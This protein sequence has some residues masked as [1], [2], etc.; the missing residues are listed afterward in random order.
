VI[1]GFASTAATF[2]PV[3][4]SGGHL[5]GVTIT[6][7]SKDGP[8]TDT[9]TNVENFKFTDQTL[10][11]PQ[12]LPPTITSANSASEAE[13]T[14]VTNVVYHIAT[15]D[16]NPNAVL[17][18]ALGGTDAG[19]FNVSST[20]DVTFKSV[21]NFETQ[22]TYNIIVHANDGT[23]DVSEAVTIH[24]TDVAPAAVADS[25][26][27]V[28]NVTATVNAAHGVLA[29]D[30]DIAGG[31]LT[32]VLVSG[33]THDSSFTLNADGSFTYKSLSTFSGT[34]SF[35]YQASD[36]TDLSNLVMVTLNVH[37]ANDAPV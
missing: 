36:G 19:D 34:D 28:K 1:Y 31:A 26:V 13:G 18:Y 25:Y 35:T 17:T 14:P 3:L 21:P 23:T 7:Q 12:L 33:P 30:S 16:Q 4:D 6:Y 24:V 9:I 5:I 32:A 11:L 29:N 2:A 27:E 20:G 22:S 37:N 8:V 15:T 10:T